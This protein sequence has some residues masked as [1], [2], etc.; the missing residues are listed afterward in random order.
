MQMSTMAGSH[1]FE[2]L[3]FGSV[4][5]APRNLYPAGNEEEDDFED[6]E[7]QEGQ[8]DCLQGHQGGLECGVRRVQKRLGSARRNVAFLVKKKAL[9]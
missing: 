2:Q 1:N 5:V 8:V 4:F 6:R 3:R 7:G 9:P